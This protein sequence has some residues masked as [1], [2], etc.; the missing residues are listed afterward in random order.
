MLRHTTLQ[1]HDTAFGVPTKGYRNLG[2]ARKVSFSKLT[3][4]LIWDANLGVTVDSRLS[5]PGLSP[6]GVT[7]LCSCVLVKIL[8]ILIVHLS[9]QVYI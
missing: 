3:T 9:T 6:G 7:A 5:G 1:C 2:N 4:G 8:C